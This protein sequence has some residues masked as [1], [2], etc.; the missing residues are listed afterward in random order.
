MYSISRDVNSR[1]ETLH[2]DVLACKAHITWIACKINA[3]SERAS[4]LLKVSLDVRTFQCPELLL[5]ILLHEYI[6]YNCHRDIPILDSANGCN[7]TWEPIT[8]TF[9]W[10]ISIRVSMLP[11]CDWSMAQGKTHYTVV[12]VLFSDMKLISES[13]ARLSTRT[14]TQGSRATFNKI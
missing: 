7:F 3:L 1:I 14:M 13:L 6:L 12:V 8:Q 9:K 5:S 2:N 10:E 11:K 4:N